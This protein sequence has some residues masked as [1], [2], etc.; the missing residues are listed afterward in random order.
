MIFF[1]LKLRF[2]ALDNFPIAPHLISPRFAVVALF[3]A[4]VAAACGVATDE[5]SPDAA[6][7]YRYYSN[8][9]Y[10]NAP[11]LPRHSLND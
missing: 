11:I 1:A 10:R 9:Y 6:C 3:R 8:C 2:I 7:Q 4:A 5:E